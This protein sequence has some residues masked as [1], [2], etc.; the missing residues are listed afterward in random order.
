M[1]SNR[2][3]AA[4]NDIRTSLKQGE[5]HDHVNAISD[6]RVGS[7]MAG[8][9]DQLER[10]DL[11]AG[12]D[13]LLLACLRAKPGER[14]LLVWEDSRHGFYDCIAAPFVAKRA[15]HLG[16]KVTSM[17]AH[18][19]DDDP[20][21]SERL[22]MAMAG[23]DHTVFFA[24]VGDQLRFGDMAGE[25]TKTISYA[26]DAACLGSP[27]GMTSYGLTEDLKTCIDQKMATAGEI[28]ITCPLGTELI[29]KPE[30]SKEDE[31][32]EVSVR[33]FPLTIGKPVLASGFSGRVAL[34]RWLVGTGSRYY[35]PYVVPL[36]A[37]IHA[38]LEHGT[39]VSFEGP[40]DVVKIARDH[41]RH[42]GDLFDIDP[43]LVHSWHAGFQPQT[44]YPLPA[45]HNPAR[46]SSLVFGSPRLLHFHVCG[47]E[48][49]GEISW[50]VINPT[51]ELD[52]QDAW[53]QGDFVLSQSDE[54]Q[55][56]LK[57]HS[58]DCSIFEPPA[59]GIGI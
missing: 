19:P 42:V 55:A 51:V 41:H 20:D 2:L 32:D 37:T 6:E 56:M 11:A 22:K 54:L 43:F 16:L 13:N 33:R 17:E 48:P 30:E 44:F 50:S 10:L 26:Y 38:Y 46:W 18:P 28:R 35:Q 12:A 57:H 59:R 4:G 3:V 34:A 36:E 49:P 31:T 53:Q 47:D 9:V 5:R 40:A 52:G 7:L 39:I 23:A 45:A 14:L 29:G 21:L 58:C 15:H 8:D 1:A 24:R 27:F 25:G